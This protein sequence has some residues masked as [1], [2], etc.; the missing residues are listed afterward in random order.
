MAKKPIKVDP[1][2]GKIILSESNIQDQIVEYLLL[3]GFMVIRSNSFSGKQT[4]V[5][6]KTLVESARFVMSYFIYKLKYRDGKPASSGKPDL[7]VM[8]N[9]RMFYIETK[10]VKGKLSPHQEEFIAWAEK[11]GMTVLVAKSLDEVINFLK[12]YWIW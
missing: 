6:K 8:R 1:K 2:T 3:Q 12:T 10:T 7:E 9:G 11:H 4:H 5:S